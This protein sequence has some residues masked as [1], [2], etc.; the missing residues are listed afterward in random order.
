MGSVLRGFNPTV[1]DNS[2]NLNFGILILKLAKHIFVN[3]SSQ[4]VSIMYLNYFANSKFQNIISKNVRISGLLI[5]FMFMN[6]DIL[7]SQLGYVRSKTIFMHR[8]QLSFF[9]PCHSKE[10]HTHTFAHTYTYLYTH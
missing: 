2:G 10:T 3:K 5:L 9:P 8:Y 7:V 6:V 4:K 1:T